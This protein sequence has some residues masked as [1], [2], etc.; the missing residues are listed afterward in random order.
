MISLKII[1]CVI[2]SIGDFPAQYFSLYTFSERVD[3]KKW[4]VCENWKRTKPVRR[5][6]DNSC[7]S[8][9]V[10]NQEFNKHIPYS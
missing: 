2:I 3:R 6:K 4:C 10:I 9:W 5:K 7:S 8:E 1:L